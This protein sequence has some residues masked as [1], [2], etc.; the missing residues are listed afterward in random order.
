MIKEYRWISARCWNETFLSTSS[1]TGLLFILKHIPCKAVHVYLKERRKVRKKE[2]R[3]KKTRNPIWW[4]KR[5][6]VTEF[7]TKVFS[8]NTTGMASR[9]PVDMLRWMNKTIKCEAWESQEN[10][11]HMG[12]SDTDEVCTPASTELILDFFFP[13]RNHHNWEQKQTC[14]SS[15]HVYTWA[16]TCQTSGT[17]LWSCLPYSP[18]KTVAAD[19][20]PLLRHRTEGSLGCEE[21]PSH[22]S[23]LSQQVEKVWPQRTKSTGPPRWRLDRESRR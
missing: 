5:F 12:W 6:S 2:K 10:K 4:F 17:I 20:G 11:H 16:L 19:S 7:F 9:S 8:D 18:E 14:V 13:P 1:K 15:S 21:C 22:S 3:R 23:P